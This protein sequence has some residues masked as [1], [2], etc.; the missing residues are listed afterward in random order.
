MI[1]NWIFD[2]DLTL[3][4]LNGNY[5]SY[6]KIIKP[7]NIRQYLDQLKGRK[8][9]FTNGTME[10]SITCI[11]LL[12]LNKIFHKILCREL[13]GLKPS[14]NSYIKTY[15]H[16]GMKQNEKV[17]FFEDTLINLEMAKKFGWITIL[18][19]RNP[20][21]YELSN[22]NVNFHFKDIISAL[23]YFLSI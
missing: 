11:H 8:I 22:K 15:H 21:S 13:T 17:F 20:S 18:I 10:H 1:N 7:K 2:L 14:I 9:L 12:D 5:F 23:E 19:K 3:Y 16:S 4:E 6:D